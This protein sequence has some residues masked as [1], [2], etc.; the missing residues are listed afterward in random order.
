MANYTKSYESV[1]APSAERKGRDGNRVVEPFDLGGASPASGFKFTAIPVSDQDRIHRI[2]NYEG[3]ILILGE[4]GTGKSTLAKKLHELSK[5]REGPFV[6]RG[7]GEFDSGTLKAQLFGHAKG[8][9]TGA[10]SPLR[11]LLEMADGGTLVL[12]DIDYLPLEAQ[13]SLLRFLDDGVYSRLGEPCVDHRSD[14]RLIVTSNKDL[15]QLCNEGRFLPDLLNRIQRWAIWL[16]PLRDKPDQL[17]ELAQAF[18]KEFLDGGPG[19]RSLVF[20]EDALDLLCAMP[21]PGNIRQ[22]RHAVE[23]LALFSGENAKQLHWRAVARVLL[24]G[25]NRPWRRPAGSPRQKQDERIHQV[26][27]ATRGNVAMASRILGCSRTTIYARIKSNGWQ[28]PR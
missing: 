6:R 12:D 4:R 8:A 10:V 7:C 13:S 27:S 5:R 16:A 11:G 21:W 14:V 17:R 26:L 24:D 18:L 22:L 25:A 23:K 20:T 15:E 19:K 2:A 28:L 3:A 1:V 9:F